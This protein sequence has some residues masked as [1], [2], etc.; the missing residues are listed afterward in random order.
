M[1]INTSNTN[2]SAN[3][4]RS[5]RLA[6]KNEQTFTNARTGNVRYY[7]ESFE[8]TYDERYAA[9]K[10]A[11]ASDHTQEVWGGRPATAQDQFAQ[12]R[13]FMHRLRE[14]IMSIRERIFGKLGTFRTSY[15]LYGYQNPL[16][17]YGDYDP[18]N[19]FI[20]MQT[21]PDPFAQEAI[22][23]LRA[24]GGG[25]R[26]NVWHRVEHSIYEYHEEEQLTFATTGQVQTAD[27]RTIDFDLTMNLSREFTQRTETLLEGVEV[28]M[29]DPIVISLDGLPPALSDTTW[30]F[31]IDADG[32]KDN[33]PEL[34]QG[35]GF[36][37]YD[38]NGDGVI[39]DGSELFGA[40]TGNG[41]YELAEL[42]SDG[43]GWIDEA[44]EAYDLLS[45]WVKD[46]SG[47]DR[48]MSLREAKVGAILLDSLRT[49]FSHKSKTDNSLKAQVR[50]SG[51]YLTEDGLAGGLQQMDFVKTA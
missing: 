11:E 32:I 34:A 3:S 30:S 38:K 25:A 33:I 15:G 40:R 27:G 48:L 41:F 50:R 2:L 12:A 6:R 4:A 46:V 24:A 37:A 1:I 20:G 44:D 47:A 7:S 18:M 5:E 36:L 23:D 31:D 51:M 39:N 45:V 49:D 42:D 22:Y 26:T 43:N 29:T 17:G 10:N 9:S 35:A 28:L 16:L 8:A 13:E 19:G 21:R 14:Y